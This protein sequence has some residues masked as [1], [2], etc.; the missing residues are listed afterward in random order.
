MPF[1]S[2]RADLKLTPEDRA[3]LNQV[4]QV[5]NSSRFVDQSPRKIWRPYWTKTSATV[6]TMYRIVK[7]YGEARE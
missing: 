1:E 5:L 3:T 2:K 4:A 6:R 7:S